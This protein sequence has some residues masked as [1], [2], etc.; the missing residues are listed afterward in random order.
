MHS[1]VRALP[2]YNRHDAPAILMDG[3]SIAR[4]TE[5][6]RAVTAQLDAPAGTLSE[7]LHAGIYALGAAHIP[8]GIRRQAREACED[9]FYSRLGLEPERALDLHAPLPPSLELLPDPI[10]KA[11]ED[12]VELVVDGE[13][14]DL[15]E[16]SGEAELD[17]DDLRRRVEDDCPEAFVLPPREHYVVEAISK[18]DDPGD[19]GWA[20]FLDLW[21]ETARRGCTSRASC[22][23]RATAST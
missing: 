2:G 14:E 8:K 23:R 18:S 19:P 7:A 9:Y 20:Y 22:T 4:E 21:T 16:L 1:A 12:L 6:G 10:Y 15:S 5:Q 13:W 17:P 3:P 11:L